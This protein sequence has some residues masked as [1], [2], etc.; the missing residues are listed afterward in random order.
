MIICDNDNDT[1]ELIVIS[2]NS[3]S[4]EERVDPIKLFP[5]FFFGSD[6]KHRRWV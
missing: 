6:P 5:V 1:R 2:D 3:D 4:N